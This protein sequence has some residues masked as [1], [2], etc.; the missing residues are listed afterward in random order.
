MYVKITGIIGV[1]TIVGLS[2]LHGLDGIVIASGMG[3]VAG[4]A[5]YEVGVHKK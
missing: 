1:V 5:G 3:I 4:L 2:V